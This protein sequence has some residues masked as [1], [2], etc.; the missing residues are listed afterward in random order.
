MCGIF[1]YVGSRRASPVLIE[2]LRQLEYRGYDSAGLAVLD[3]GLKVVRTAGKIAVLERRLR[4]ERLDGSCGVAHTRW[5]THGAATERNAHPHTGCRGELAVVHNGIIENHLALRRELQARGHRFQS[6]T[7]TEVLA[8]LIEDAY[9]GRLEQAVMRALARVRGAYGIAVLHREEPNRIVLARCGSPLVIG[10]GAGEHF[11]ASDVTALIRYTRH[12]IHLEDGDVAVLEPG[13]FSIT[14]MSAGAAVDREVETVDWDVDEVARGG[15]PHY[16][17]KEICEQPE[18]IRNAIRGRIVL[19]DGIPKLGG[20]EAVIEQVRRCRHLVIVSCGTSF[21]AGMVG[22]Y[23]MEEFTDL[24]VEVEL[25]S[26]FRYRRLQLG[27]RTM[28]LAISQSGETADT[29]AAVREAKRKGALCLGLVNAVGSSIARETHAG[30][31]MHAGPEIGVASTKAFTSELVI[32]TLMALLFG[33][34]RRLSLFEGRRVLEELQRLPELV[35]RVLEQRQQIRELAER[36]ADCEHFLYIGRRFS[37]PIALEGALKLKEIV[38]VHAEG[39]AAG[40]MK[41][42]PLA[43]IDP[44]YVCVALCPRNEVQ[45]KTLSNMQEVRARGGRMIALTTEGDPAARELADAVI[46]VPAT[47]ECLSPVLEVVPLQLFAYDLAVLRGRDV[48][49]PRNLAKSVTVE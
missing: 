10:I 47:L 20:L 33:R 8:H 4:G 19:E 22:R 31:Y 29:L 44:S 9:E 45:D 13:R 14:S 48:D 7:D 34:H 39:Y 23:L 37:Y 41:H 32:L 12:V 17:L 21:Y 43:L 11:A 26:E 2:G 24:T 40:E 46:E 18:S 27:E 38:Y 25:A 6:E 16:M 1:G 28:V 36:F 42:G 3:G 5:A 15:Y 35:A 49:K 30:V